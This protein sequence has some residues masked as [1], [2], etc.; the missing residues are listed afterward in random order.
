[1]RVMREEI[2]GPVVAAY[3]FAD[4]HEAVS[5]ANDSDYGLSSSIWTGDAG[6]AA[7]IAEALETGVVSI[8]SSASV[9]ITAPFG[10]MKASGLGRELGTA[11]LDA[12]TETK[13]VYH[14]IGRPPEKE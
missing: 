13:T 6:R 12:Y 8:N 7:R 2:F 3:P 4:E 1:M 9:H 11:A 14:D 5:V 10:G